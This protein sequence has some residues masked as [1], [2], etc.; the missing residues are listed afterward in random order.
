MIH[1][2]GLVKTKTQ[3]NSM[4]S[5]KKVPDNPSP[6]SVAQLKQTL[7]QVRDQVLIEGNDYTV[8]RKL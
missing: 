7:N 8:K 2:E 4:H 6:T 3:S 5:L 1:F